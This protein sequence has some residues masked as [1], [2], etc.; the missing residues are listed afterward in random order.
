MQTRYLSISLKIDMG[1]SALVFSNAMINIF[2]NGHY[3]Y[4]LG[5]QQVLVLNYSPKAYNRKLMLNSFAEEIRLTKRIVMPLIN[6][7]FPPLLEMVSVECSAA[8]KT[9]ERL[10]E[11]LLA[12]LYLTISAFYVNKNDE[13][14]LT[15]SFFVTA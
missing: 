6:P 3:Q 10:R 15:I 1:K 2:S 5:T 12:S 9:R 11:E 8:R 4:L 7:P 13:S 14:N